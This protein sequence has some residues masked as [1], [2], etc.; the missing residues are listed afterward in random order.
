[1]IPPFLTSALLLSPRVKDLS[2]NCSG[3]LSVKLR[4]DFDFAQDKL[5]EG[6]H[7]LLRFFAYGS[8]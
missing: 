7:L 3:Q 6:S 1:M 8:E 4:T 5:R 2:S